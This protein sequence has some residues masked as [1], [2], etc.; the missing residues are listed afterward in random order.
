MNVPAP[1]RKNGWSLGKNTH[2]GVLAGGRRPPHMCT[3]PSVC[4]CFKPLPTEFEIRA[5]D[6]NI[7]LLTFEIRAHDPTDI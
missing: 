5:H 4:Q 3:A 7:V 6:E 2:D 1:A